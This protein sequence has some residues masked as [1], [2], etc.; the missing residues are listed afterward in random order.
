MG[1]SSR[2]THNV[3]IFRRR[4]GVWIWLELEL[5]LELELCRLELCRVLQLGVVLGLWRGVRSVC[6]QDGHADVG[7]NRRPH[8]ARL[9]CSGRQ[10]CRPMRLHPRADESTQRAPGAL[11]GPPLHRLGHP[12]KP[13][14]S[15]WSRLP[16]IRRRRSGRGRRSSSGTSPVLP[17]APPT[18]GT[19]SS[20]LGASP[21]VLTAASAVGSVV[22]SPCP[23]LGTGQ[24]RRPA[25]V[26]PTGSTAST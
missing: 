20:P 24:T 3:F 23:R 21:R 14:S 12:R 1:L 22:P 13:T 4:I 5:E 9:G 7:R 19:L 6:L 16:H 15:K 8:P 10:H 26:S 11:R 2:E 17:L 18:D 25:T